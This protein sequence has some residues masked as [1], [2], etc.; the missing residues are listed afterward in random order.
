MIDMA[1][2]RLKYPKGSSKLDRAIAAK[3][4]RLE[5]QRQLAI[6]ARAV[7]DRDHWTCRH[8]G[9]K[10]SSTRALDPT[11]AEAHHVVSRSDVAVKFDVRNGITLSL[12]AHLAVELGHYRI[13]GTRWFRTGGCRYVDCTYAV[14]FVR[15]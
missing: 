6:W 1:D 9:A 2:P 11:R 3:A 4:A 14:T 10:V 13:D 12:A 8:T 5:D 7:K 15:T